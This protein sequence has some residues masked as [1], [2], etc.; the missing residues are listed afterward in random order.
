MQIEYFAL[1]IGNPFLCI[2]LDN[3]SRDT[4]EK[5]LRD[6]RNAYIEISQSCKG[7]SKFPFTK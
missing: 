3:V 6:F 4:R 7:F 5:F 2:D 1:S